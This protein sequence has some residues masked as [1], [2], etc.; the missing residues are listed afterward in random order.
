MATSSDGA[1]GL[2]GRLAQG[3]DMDRIGSS[4]TAAS[5]E[6]RSVKR[7]RRQSRGTTSN[8]KAGSDSA[9]A[10]TGVPDQSTG[11]FNVCVYASCY[12]VT[13]EA[14]TMTKK[15]AMARVT[16]VG[17]FLSSATRT[18]TSSASGR[19]CRPTHVQNGGENPRARA[20]G[21]DLKKR[22]ARG[23]LEAIPRRETS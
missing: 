9:S 1:V 11:P 17:V 18:A 10:P 15:N 23:G 16:Q 5:R 8:A 14:H 3:L 13:V 6:R 19:S 12:H 7:D 4:S 2:L 21:G 22:G 20:N